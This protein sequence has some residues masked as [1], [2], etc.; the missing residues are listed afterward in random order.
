MTTAM[1]CSSASRAVAALDGDCGVVV[2]GN[3]D[4]CNGGPDIDTVVN[5][6]ASTPG[7]P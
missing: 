1:T 7:V 4:R 6:E 5:C 2:R 3:L